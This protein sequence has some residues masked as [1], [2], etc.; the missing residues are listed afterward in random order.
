MSNLKVE[1]R[2]LNKISS[3][4][5]GLSII[6]YKNIKLITEIKIVIKNFIC[7]SELKDLFNLGSSDMNVAK[8]PMNI[9]E[10]IIR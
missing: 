2:K 8:T 10:D 7:L 3:F 4:S 9:N 5:K 1:N 6:E